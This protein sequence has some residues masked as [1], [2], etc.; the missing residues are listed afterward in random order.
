MLIIGLIGTVI[1]AMLLGLKSSWGYAV[2]VVVIYVILGWSLNRATKH[3]SN[4]YLK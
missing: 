1:G 3:Y 4:K 2:L